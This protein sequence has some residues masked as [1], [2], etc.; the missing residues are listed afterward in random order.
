M[1]HS[2]ILRGA[3]QRLLHD[4]SSSHSYDCI[5]WYVLLTMCCTLCA[6]WFCV[7][8]ASRA[9]AVGSYYLSYLRI[10]LLVLLVHDASDIGV[11]MLKLSNYTKM[12][13][14]RGWYIVEVC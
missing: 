3:H 6:C 4:V 2:P 13:D 14:R 10:G 1:L 11:D 12:R 9:V 8:R 7:S 5:D